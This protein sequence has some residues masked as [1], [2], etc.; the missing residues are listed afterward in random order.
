M[1]IKF[2]LLFLSM[3]KC[4]KFNFFSNYFAYSL[5]LAICNCN[6]NEDDVSY[7]SFAFQINLP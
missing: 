1:F 2:C 7:D 3:T 6:Q 5:S 4:L